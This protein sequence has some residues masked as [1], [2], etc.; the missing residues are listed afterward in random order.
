MT[1]GETLGR[2]P[3]ASL[4]G[5][6]VTLHWAAQI[7]S[8]AGATWVEPRADWSHTALSW[9]PSLRAMASEALPRGT[10]ALLIVDDLSLAVS[11]ADGAPAGDR[12]SL[13]DRTLSEG[14][15]WLASAVARH[16]GVQVRA[17]ERPRHEL[18]MRSEEDPFEL[19]GHAFGEL[20]GWYGTAAQLFARIAERPGASPVRLWPHH[21]DI[22]TL[23]TIDRGKTSEEA[24][25]VGVGLSPG[26]GSYDDPY[27]YVT[28]W[29]YPPKDT[30]EPVLPAGHWH[31]QGWC[32]AVLTASELLASDANAPAA[33]A[34]TFLDVAIEK[35][36]LLLA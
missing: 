26:D 36:T 29:P 13:A 30:P 27:W 1:G 34:Q 35:A 6:R 23:I 18:P 3:P 21:F 14:L 19:D 7:I 12:F 28:P 24:R 4:A 16:E 32:G 31:T 11:G 9:I 25:S 33:C 2:V 22:A 10:R 8:A 17:L 20:A 15:A 5:A